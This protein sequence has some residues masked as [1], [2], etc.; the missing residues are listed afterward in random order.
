MEKGWVERADGAY[1]LTRGGERI[2]EAFGQMLDTVGQIE[3]L[4]EFLRLFPTDVEAPDFVGASDVQVTSAT[5]ADPYAPARQQTGILK[6]ADGIRIL[7]PAIDLESTEIIVE[8]VTEHGLEVEA[9]VSPMVEST[10]ESDAFAPL[11]REKVQ[12]GRSSVLVAPESVPFYLGLAD[13]GRVQVGL[14]DEDGL[15]RV[16]VETT[17][18]DIL[19][20]A[21]NLYQ[22]YRK[23][24]RSKAAAE[25]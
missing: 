13:D 5:D 3:E 24:A 25:F 16:L 9:I 18:R 17:D 19:A 6:T 2:T 23:S 21:E 12:T 14:A 8:Q 4:T 7:L 1:R 22:R 15:P 20:W 10:M 11:I